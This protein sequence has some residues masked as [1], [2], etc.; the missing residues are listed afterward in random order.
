[1]ARPKFTKAQKEFADAI[2][3]LAWQPRDC[4]KQRPLLKLRTCPN[5]GLLTCSGARGRPSTTP[6]RRL[7]ARDQPVLE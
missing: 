1:M 6:R 3:P 7:L 4:P 2:K 5:G